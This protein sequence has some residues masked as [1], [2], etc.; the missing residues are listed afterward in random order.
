MGIASAS[1]KSNVACNRLGQGGSTSQSDVKLPSLLLYRAEVQLKSR[2]E[3]MVRC[4][5]RYNS[6]LWDDVFAELPQLTAR[7]I[8]IV[9]FGAWYPRFNFN[10]PRVR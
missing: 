2:G 5:G 7:D 1:S 9:N 8:I 6:S 4:F 10:E 3:I